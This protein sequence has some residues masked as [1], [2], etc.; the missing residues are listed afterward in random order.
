MK[1]LEAYRS[2]ELCDIVT[3][4]IHRMADRSFCFMEVC[5]GH[6]MAIRK[7]GIPSLLP[8]SIRLLSGPGCPVCVTSRLYIDQAIHLGR[9]PDNIIC[10]YGDLLRVPGSDGSLEQARAAGH[11]I[12]VV[13]SSLQALQIAIDHPTKK[14]IFLGIGFETTAPATAAAIVGARERKIHNFFVLSAH[15]VM[16]PAMDAIISAGIP[17][18][19][20]ICP[21]HVSTITGTSIYYGIVDKHQVGCVISGFEP[22]DLLQ[23]I[24]MLVRQVVENAPKVEIQYTRAVRP[25]G[26]PKAMELIREVF[27]PADDWWRGLGVLKNSG[28]SLCSRYHEFDAKKVFSLPDYE[29][30]EPLSCLCGDVLKGLKQPQ[31]CLLFAESCT[32]ANPVGACMVSSEGACQTYYHYERKITGIR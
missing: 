2:R 11:K 22:L 28:L 30:K 16:P 32:P 27:E 26:N 29:I 10:T 13:L 18:N 7:F 9:Q 5:G 4:H 21:G 20:Y 14:I 6:T 17:V 19:G 12:Q 3:G 15:K 8:S 24:Y 23:T 1:H 25:E 31:E